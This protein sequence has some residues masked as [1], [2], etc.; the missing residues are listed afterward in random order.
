MIDEATKARVR[1]LLQQANDLHLLGNC[2]SRRD[3]A[4]AAWTQGNNFRVAAHRIW[5]S[6]RGP[7][8]DTKFGSVIDLS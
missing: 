5:N 4:Y 1:G 8:M 7:Y 3:L 6:L 2:T